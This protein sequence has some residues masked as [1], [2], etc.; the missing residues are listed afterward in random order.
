MTFWNWDL[1]LDL[2]MKKDHEFLDD[3]LILDR[4]L[5]SINTYLSMLK[6][7]FQTTKNKV[8]GP[9]FLYKNREKIKGF[10]LPNPK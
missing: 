10:I 1:N 3:N 9:Q 4:H 6:I 5:I 2:R 7:E 8:T